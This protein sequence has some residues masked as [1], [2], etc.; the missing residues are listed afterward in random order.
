MGHL[1]KFWK[2]GEETFSD[3]SKSQ[4][5]CEMAVTDTFQWVSME[6][7]WLFNVAQL[8]NVSP[9]DGTLQNLSKNNSII[10][11]P[12]KEKPSTFIKKDYNMFQWGWNQMFTTAD[13]KTQQYQYA[14]CWP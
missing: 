9:L 8:F 12:D 7:V 14:L 11:T 4:T 5:P 13:H 2:S 10:Q 6:K 1:E 3:R